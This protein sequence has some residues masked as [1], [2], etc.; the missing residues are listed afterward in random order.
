MNHLSNPKIALLIWATIG[1]ICVAYLIGYAHFLIWDYAT[2]NVE[3]A[4]FA[5]QNVTI[6]GPLTQV[7]YDEE[8]SVR[9]IQ[10]AVVMMSSIVGT[11]AFIFWVSVVISSIFDRPQVR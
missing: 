10:R 5:I 4:L 6:S 3:H 2:P 9:N 7:S 1:L 8:R 11:L